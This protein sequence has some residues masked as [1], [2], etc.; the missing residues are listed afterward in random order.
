M[1]KTLEEIAQ[2]LSSPQVMRK[3]VTKETKQIPAKEVEET[4]PVPKVQLIYAFNGTGKTRLSRAMKDLIAPKVEGEAAR[5]KFLYYSAFTEDLFYWNNDLLG[6]AEPKLLIQPNSFT[7][8]ILGEQGQE[9]NIT[10]VFQHYTN[11]NLTPTFNQ[12]Y[13]R[14]NQDGTQ[15]EVK[16]FSEMKPF[17]RG[18]KWSNSATRA[19]R[20]GSSR[21]ASIHVVCGDISGDG[22]VMPAASICSLATGCRSIEFISKIDGNI[23]PFSALREPGS[24]LIQFLFRNVKNLT[25]RPELKYCLMLALST[26]NVLPSSAA[27]YLVS[28]PH[29]SWHQIMQ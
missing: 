27:V 18:A 29:T 3:I 8:W 7:D 11:A 28:P 19:A 9:V 25:N 15:T 2:Q 14:N 10:R 4:K 13:T 6:D 12:A 22:C 24:F 21:T 20:S 1:S 17:N 5:N 16:A 26:R 23:T